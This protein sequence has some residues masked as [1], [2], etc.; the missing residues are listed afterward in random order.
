MSTR[1]FRILSAVTCLVGIILLNVSFSYPGP[2]LNPTSAQ[3]A[4]FASQHLASTLKGAWLQAVGSLLVI[5]F[6]FALVCLAG[7]TARLAGWMSFLGGCI[8]IMVSLI[9]VVFYY[10][11]LYTNPVATG[12]ISFNLIHAVQHLYFIIAGAAL[13]IPLGIVILSSRVLSRVFGYLALVLGAAFAILGV[14][15]LDSLV[16][17]VL[18]QAFASVQALWWL[19]AAVAIIVQAARR[20]RAV[21]VE[22]QGLSSKQPVIDNVDAQ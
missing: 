5:L 21:P 6:D 13:F 1:L 15:F 9:E 20:P 17:P 18:V 10:G 14:V 22:A 3:M 4:A 11:L 8:L 19:A 12:L 7:A 2:P 16:L